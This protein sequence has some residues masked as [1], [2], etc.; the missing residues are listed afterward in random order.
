MKKS[1]EIIPIK[2]DELR[3][4]PLSSVWAFESNPVNSWAYWDNAFSKDECKQI[5]KYGNNQILNNA[6]TG[7]DK[8]KNVVRDSEIAWLYPSEETYWIY[9]RMT[10]IVTNLNDRFFKFD[11]FGSI[12]GFQFTKYT[13]PTGKY[14]KH[15][16]CCAGGL[17]RK[18]SF[19]LQLSEPEEYDGGELCLYFE[20]KPTITKKD[21]GY[22]CLFPSYVL[23]EVKPVK[24]GIRYSL[25]TWLTG[26]PFK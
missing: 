19:T 23:H 11:I 6:T 16:D 22:V 20:D 10:D 12:E 14:G 9:Q 18:L 4:E 5:I 13:A 3:K 25:V 2:S 21:C 17:T 1:A 15:I 7:V 26:K 8:K 24:Q